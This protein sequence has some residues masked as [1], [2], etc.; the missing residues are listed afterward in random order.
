MGTTL[1][2]VKAAAK[3]G[4]AEKKRLAARGRKAVATVL[5][6]KK[7]IKKAFYE[8]GRALA[9][10]K[11][12]AV[13]RA[14]GH[15]SFEELCASMKMSDSQADRLIAITEHFSAREAK[16]LITSTKA[17]AIIDL[18]SAMGGKTTPRGL[19]ERGTVH[20]A[21]GKTIDV[22]SASS[23]AIDAAARSLRANRKPSG[24]GGLAIS[25]EAKRFFARLR[26]EAKK[27]RLGDVRIEEIAASEDEEAKMRLVAGVKDARALAHALASASAALRG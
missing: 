3:L 25:P 2:K 26:S 1:V 16:E 20:L 14:L 23:H 13:F 17:T 4:A 7:V 8:M 15:P 27:A 6:M 5:A 10:L 22:G 12:P 18:A 21:N 11:D 19:L 9:V 24:H